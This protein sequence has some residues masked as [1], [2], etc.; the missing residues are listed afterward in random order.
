MSTAS[1]KTYYSLEEYLALE[2]RSEVRHEYF[3]GQ[4]KQMSGA[5]RAHNVV[6]SNL[7]RLIANR[8]VDQPCEVYQADMRV[9]VSENGLHTYPDLVVACPPLGF[10]TI[11][12]LETLL[13]PVAIVEVLSPTTEAYDRGR[14]LARYQ[15][16]PSLRE[17]I[18]VA[19]DEPRVDH[20]QHLPDGNWNLSI[21]SGLER[22]FRIECIDCE[23]SLSQ[24]YAKIEFPTN[25]EEPSDGPT[26]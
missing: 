16:I 15:H 11:L 10:E 8:L 19:Q 20:L 2:S 22:S 23:L 24:I 21:H 3:A 26:T 4:I 14:K 9:K 1:V 25:L 12:G 17:Y 18:L 5:T 7:N 6:A 13:N